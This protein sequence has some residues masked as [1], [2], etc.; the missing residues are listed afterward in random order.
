MADSNYN[1]D[2]KK[3]DEVLDPDVERDS[4]SIAKGDLLS[5]EHVDPVL[6]AKMHLVNDVSNI[7]HD[8]YSEL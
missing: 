5:Q 2:E 4:V 7:W 6:S 3:E 8:M 1:F